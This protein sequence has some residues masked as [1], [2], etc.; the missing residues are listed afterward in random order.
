MRRLIGAVVVLF[1]IYGCNNGS[2]SDLPNQGLITYKITYS[3]ELLKQPISALLPE[4]MNLYFADDKL[5]INIKGDLNLFSL[6]FLS[7]AGGDSCFT[8]FKLVNRKMVYRLNNTEKWFFFDEGTSP[9][10]KVIE[11]S[12]RQIAGFDSQLVELT[13]KNSP[14]PVVQGFFTT[15]LDI[16]SEQLRSPFGKVPG[17]PLDFS[18]RYNGELFHFKAIKYLPFPPNEPMVVPN[19]YVVSTLSEIRSVIDSIIN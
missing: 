13:Y 10:F 3:Q 11:D 12:V 1:L 15:L 14:H 19:E 9:V 16:K 2:K 7:L 17:V 8:L 18:V 4:E 6:E 5:K